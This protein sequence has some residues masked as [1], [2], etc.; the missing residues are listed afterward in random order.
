MKN[1]M[2][3]GTIGAN[4]GRNVTA[5]SK[6]IA[7][8]GSVVKREASKFKQPN[9]F[10]RALK[11]TCVWLGVGTADEDDELARQYRDCR[12]GIDSCTESLRDD[13]NE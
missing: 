2:T 4:N 12:I 8:S 1:D 7:R 13:G 10:Q 9:I 5:G 3:T 6:A 11:N